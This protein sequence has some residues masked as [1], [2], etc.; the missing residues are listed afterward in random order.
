MIAR[1]HSNKSLSAIGADRFAVP[2]VPGLSLALGL[3][4]IRL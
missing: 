3:R 4:L 1:T 2:A